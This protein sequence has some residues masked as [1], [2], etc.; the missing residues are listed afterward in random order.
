MLLTVYSLKGIEFNGEATSLNVK[1]EA[2]EITVL[3]GHRPLISA[4]RPGA[5]KI[6]KLDGMM[7][8]INI[9]SG[10]LEMSPNNR[11]DILLD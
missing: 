1:T 3:N 2:G 5:L 7:E 9:S 8:E 10:F 11:L 4:L 6:T